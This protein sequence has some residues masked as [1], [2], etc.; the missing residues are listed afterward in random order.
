M[1]LELVRGAGGGRGPRTR[2]AGS[3]GSAP[4]RRRLEFDRARRSRLNLVGLSDGTPWDSA[5]RGRPDHR[6]VR[7]VQAA[8]W[9]HVNSA[10][11]HAKGRLISADVTAVDSDSPAGVVLLERPLPC[12]QNPI[13][14]RGALPV[15]LRIG[16]RP[17][18]G[19]VSRSAVG[20][21]NRQPEARVLDETW[22]STGG[23][24]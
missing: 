2:V 1:T 8:R 24:D 22:P 5:A 18:Q 19:S 4:R 20:T 9:R 16:Q 15:G 23:A 11:S 10:R 6:A 17:V 21:R 13:A 14:R 7:F 12:S 3:A